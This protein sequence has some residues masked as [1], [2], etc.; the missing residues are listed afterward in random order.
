MRQEV[1]DF[2]ERHQLL[3]RGAT[4]LIGVSGGPDSMA[5]LH[6][7]STIRNTW[8]LQLVAISVDHQLRGEESQEDQRFV[9]AWCREHQIEHRALTA[10]VPAYQQAHQLGTQEAARILRY[11]HFQEQMEAY[12]A[13]FLVL[14]HHGD[15]QVETMLMSLVRGTNPDHLEGIPVRRPFA[16]GEII[17]PFLCL[18]KHD[19]ETYCTAHD[20]VPRRD[21]SNESTNYTR[22]YFRKKVIPLLK[23]KNSN[24]HHTVQLLSESLKSDHLFLQQEAEKMAEKL[25]QFNEKNKSATFE[26]SAF[27]SHP[28]AL[29]RRVFH[30]ILNY[31]YDEIPKKLSYVHEAHFFELLHT[32]R[33]NVQLDFPQHL[34]VEK[35]YGK[36]LFHFVKDTECTH[37]HHVVDIPGAL[38][39]PNGWVLTVSKRNHV[40]AQDDNSFLIPVDNVSLPLSVRTRLPGDRMT[41]KGLDGSKKIKDIFMDEKIPVTERDTWPLLVDH[42]G[43]ILWLMGLKKDLRH[44]EQQEKAATSFIYVQINNR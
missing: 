30:L 33:S 12:Q 23:E 22:N 35:S 8:N 21:P 32:T 29:Q 1:A 17:R 42:D 37:F 3:K 36:L 28:S 15:D 18:T 26:I 20:I 40:T 6:Y 11:Q 39:L 27:K 41:W 25:V 44:L 4:V 2:I 5:L 43:R 9:E 24:I 13:D 7:F 34:K 10:D 38:S 14:G 16:T 31:L 19:M